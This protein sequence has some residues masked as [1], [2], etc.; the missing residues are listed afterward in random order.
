MKQTKEE[1]IMKTKS[2][3]YVHIPS[4]KEGQQEE[5]KKIRAWLI[6]HFIKE[7]VMFRERDLESFDKQFPT[8]EGDKQ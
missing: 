2:D 8:K 3:N 5:R 7:D 6:K 1:I 4:Y